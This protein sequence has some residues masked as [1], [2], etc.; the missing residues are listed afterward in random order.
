MVAPEHR[1]SGLGP[2]LAREVTREFEITLAA[3]ANEDARDILSRMGYTD[4]GQLTRHVAVLDRER[5][6]A[7]T[8]SGQL[9]WPEETPLSSVPANIQIK[10]VQR[11]SS[12]FTKLW[13]RLL[14]NESQLAGTTRSAEYLN[15]RYAE[16]PQFPYCLLAA[17]IEQEFVGF[18]VYRIEQARDSE[19]RVARLVELVAQPTAQEALLVTIMQQARAAQAVAIDFF[20]GSARY[21][22]IL[23]RQGFLSDQDV[24]V[25][26]IPVLYQPLDRRRAGIR[27]LADLRNL[28][29]ETNITEWYVTKSDGDQDR[30]N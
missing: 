17:Q 19:I 2:L 12:E 14:G 23:A 4:L 9:D 24:R 8:E 10:V 3:G 5:A 15:W 27:Y 26:Q 28:P 16:H 6:A 30:P 13:E 22:Q 18:A 25:Q 29:A 1:K 7:L 20:C 21:N 11:A